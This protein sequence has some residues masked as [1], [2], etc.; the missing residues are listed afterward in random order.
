MKRRIKTES[1]RILQERSA[2][3]AKGILIRSR[4]NGTVKYAFRVYYQ[5]GNFDDYN[6]SFEDLPV[7]IDTDA[8]VSFYE[9][10]N[11]ELYLDETP[12]TLGWEILETNG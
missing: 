9:D 1:G 7:T 2:G 3:G 11:G 10:E 6:L 8:L 4:E 12:E 5:G